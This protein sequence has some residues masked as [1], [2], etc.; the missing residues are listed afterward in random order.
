MG[1]CFLSFESII[2]FLPC[3]LFTI[4]LKKK[5]KKIV[6]N[7]Y[8]CI[9]HHYF[10]S[11]HQL[12]NIHSCIKL[13]PPVQTLLL[14]IPLSFVIFLSASVLT[15]QLACLTDSFFLHLL[16]H[17]LHIIVFL[18]LLSSLS[19]FSFLSFAVFSYVSFTFKFFPYFLSLF[20]FLLKKIFFFLM[21]NSGFK[22][23]IMLNYSG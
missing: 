22:K 12:P 18:L 16:F 2:F 3:H 20:P 5:K 13:F 1:F 6:E 19:S 17:G 4:F 10:S 7:P 14:L 8:I 9:P 21:R 11:P 23:G 15:S